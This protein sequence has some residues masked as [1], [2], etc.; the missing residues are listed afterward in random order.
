MHSVHRPMPQ[1]PIEYPGMT[2]AV[3]GKWQS[4]GNAGVACQVLAWTMCRFGAEFG[5]RA[6]GLIFCFL[7]ICAFFT[8][9]YGRLR[10]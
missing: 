1:P 10:Y 6:Y 8:E 4:V 3:R 9:F 2:P 7:G 5:G